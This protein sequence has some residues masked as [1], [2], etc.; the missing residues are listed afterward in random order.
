[1][2]R[3]A[4][5]DKYIYANIENSTQ[6][7]EYQNTLLSESFVKLDKFANASIEKSKFKQFK[8]RNKT[9]RRLR[10]FQ[11]ELSSNAENQKERDELLEKLNYK[12]PKKVRL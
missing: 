9:M 11:A 4:A 2:D 10:D 5:K 6:A 3:H 12:M 8:Q 1:M 7:Q